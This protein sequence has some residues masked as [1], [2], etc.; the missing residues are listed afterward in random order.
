MDTTVALVDD[1]YEERNLRD[2]YLNE[3]RKEKENR[4]FED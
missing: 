4:R 1:E 2:I 3:Y